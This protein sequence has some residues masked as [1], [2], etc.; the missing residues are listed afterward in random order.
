M[1]GVATNFVCY[2][3]RVMKRNVTV[4]ME[5]STA[6]W[7]RVEAARRDLSVSA[8]L[9]ELLEREREKDEGYQDAQDRFLRR[10]PRPLAPEGVAYPSR[11]EIHVR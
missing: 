4:V 1:G 6:R 5:E 8:F 2:E 3:I 9:G 7:V 11:D 10:A